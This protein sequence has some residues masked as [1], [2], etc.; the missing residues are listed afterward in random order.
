MQFRKTIAQDIPGVMKI[1][2]QAQRY[3][4]NAGIPQWRDGY[5][6]QASIQQDLDQGNSY[7]LVQDGDILATMALI[8]GGESTYKKIY[9]GQWA[10]SMAYGAIH[11]IATDDRYKGQGLATV[12]VEAAERICEE[13]GISSLRVDTHNKNHSMQRML[14][15]N[16]FQYCGIIFL[17]SGDPRMAFEKVLRKL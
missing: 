7:V 13:K 1:I 6:N 10:T 11:R 9:E 8:F 5:P 4:E 17:A 3:L 2:S 15:K 16:G 14:Q 12:M